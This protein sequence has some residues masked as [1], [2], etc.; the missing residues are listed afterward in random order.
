M[1]RRFAGTCFSICGKIVL[2]YIIFTYGRQ[3]KEFIALE[4]M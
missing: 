1:R 3:V 4:V 2:G